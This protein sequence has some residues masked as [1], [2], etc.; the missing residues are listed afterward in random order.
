MSK[1]TGRN[2]LCPCG[3]GKKYKKCCMGKVLP[4]ESVESV[5]SMPVN[6]RPVSFG[7]SCDNEDVYDSLDDV[8]ESIR[9]DGYV[10]VIEYEDHEDGDSYEIGLQ[11]PHG[12]AEVSRI[13]YS[14]EDGR[15]VWE[16]VSYGLPCPACMELLGI[17]D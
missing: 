7:S 13:Y 12:H 5:P 8:L 11:C 14:L 1:K 6:L 2:D 4:V 17:I 16:G 9:K 3:S 15:L 10:P